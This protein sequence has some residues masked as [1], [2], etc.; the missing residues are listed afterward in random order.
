MRKRKSKRDVP[1][2]VSPRELA[3]ILAALRFHQD[4]NLQVTNEIPDQV[5]REIATDGGCLKPLTAQEIDRLCERL[6]LAAEPLDRAVC[7][8]DWH[9]TT[10]PTTGSGA[11]YW[12]KCRRCGATKYRCVEQDGSVSEEIHPPDEEADALPKTRQG[13]GPKKNEMPSKPKGHTP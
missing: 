2:S 11:E 8:H 10:G 9:E 4:E 12:F 7:T 1:L 6:N 3:T 13:P 5:V